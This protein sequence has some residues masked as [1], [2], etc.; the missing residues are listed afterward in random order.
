MF[1]FKILKRLAKR[2]NI[3]G[4]ELLL[5][6]VVNQAQNIIQ[7][8]TQDVQ[9]GHRCQGHNENDQAVFKNCRAAIFA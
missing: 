1:M 7:G 3:L 4:K 9:R 6:F 8:I 5:D 2:K